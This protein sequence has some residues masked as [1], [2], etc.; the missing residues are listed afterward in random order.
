MGVARQND[1]P[2]ELPR[3]PADDAV[4]RCPRCQSP[5]VVK[6]IPNGSVCVSCTG[7][8]EC[9]TSGFLPNGG[10]MIARLRACNCSAGFYV[11]RWSFEPGSVPSHMTGEMATRENE[12]PAK[13]TDPDPMK[14]P[15]MQKIANLIPNPNKPENSFNIRI[16]HKINGGAFGS[17]H[18]VK[19]IVGDKKVDVMVKIEASDHPSPQLQQEHIVYSVLRGT[20]GFGS[21]VEGLGTHLSRNISLQTADGETAEFNMLFL[22]RLGIDL[23]TIHKRMKLIKNPPDGLHRMNKHTV[24]NAASQMFDVVKLLHNA[25]FIHRD[26]KLSN[27]MM[28]IGIDRHNVHL[29]DFGLSKQYKDLSGNHMGTGKR[30]L[31]IGTT[32][33]QSAFVLARHI[34]TRRDDLIS[35]I[36]CILQLILGA[37]PWDIEWKAKKESI[38]EGISSPQERGKIY[39]KFCLK[40]KQLPANVLFTHFG[41]Y[42]DY[43]EFSEIYEYFQSLEPAQDP[44]WDFI[45]EKVNDC[46]RRHWGWF[47]WF[48]W[49]EEGNPTPENPHH[50]YYMDLID[51]FNR[52]YGRA[53]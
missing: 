41:I 37:L 33:F 45:N 49:L 18:K 12:R 53:S 27:F 23:A 44:D 19:A 6:T 5:M 15:V 29:I 50:N 48:E 47:D 39:D 24:L 36:Y 31:N 13:K 40:M 32:A 43:K 1:R 7:Y 20:L 8:P 10:R 30:N 14:Y 38:L 21:I 52:N 51:E 22:T 28:G 2:F 42:D 16:S 4:A 34:P 17:L 11:V 26:I 9:R 25:H 35:T 3:N 46:G